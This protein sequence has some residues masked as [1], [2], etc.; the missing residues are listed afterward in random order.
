MNRLKLTDLVRRVRLGLLALEKQRRRPYLLAAKVPENLMGCHFDGMD[1]ETWAR[2]DLVDI[3]VLGCG[4]TELDIP[5]FRRITAGKHIKIY[6]GWDPIHPSEGYREPPAAYWRGLYAKWWHDGADGVHVFNANAASGGYGYRQ[7]LSEIGSPDKLK[8]LDKV[9]FVQR[10]GGSHG[11]RITGDPRNWQTPR[12]MYFNTNMF[13]PLPASL[14]N[15][16]KADT[17]LTLKVADDVNAAGE[18]LESLRLRILLSDPSAEALPAGQ[19]LAAARL[20]HPA[21]NIPPAKGIEKTIEV[22]INNIPLGRAH[23]KAGWLGWSVQPGQLAVGDNLLGVKV[24]GR[25]ADAVDRVLIEKVELDVN[26]R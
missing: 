18:R 9:F 5:A 2:E 22:R 19:R 11:A 7:M 6:A 13:A 21:M 10:R 25:P 1:V 4:A 26:Y 24:T 20:H 3:F 23:V 15:D 16:G 17:L 14:A 12:H 8:Y